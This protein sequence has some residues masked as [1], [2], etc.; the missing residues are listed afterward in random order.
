M[1]TPAG[2]PPLQVGGAATSRGLGTPSA[3]T[4]STT[5]PARRT[6]RRGGS[7]TDVEASSPGAAAPA[8]EG[9]SPSLSTPAT[10]AEARLSASS[11]AGITSTPAPEP[12]PEDATAPLFD[13]DGVYVPM[14]ARKA[15]AAAASGE[16]PDASS[17]TSLTNRRPKRFGPLTHALHSLTHLST[18]RGK[19]GGAGGSRKET[20]SG[21]DS[22][23]RSALST[24]S[25]HRL[26]GQL[27]S[28]TSSASDAFGLDSGASG[29]LEG[30]DSPGFGAHLAGSSHW[31][32]PQSSEVLVFTCLCNLLMR[33]P[34]RWAATRNMTKL[35]AWYSLYSSVLARV[36]P[37][38][39]A[40]LS[41]LGLDPSFY[42]MSWVITLFSNPLGLEVAIRLWDRVLLGGS[43]EVLKC[44][45]GLTK[46]LGPALLAG[47]PTA[48]EASFHT[49]SKVPAPLRDEF[50]IAAAASAIKLT[51]AE[52]AALNAMEADLIE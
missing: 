29:D 16:A 52:V 51:A 10:K 6:R 26:T 30:G 25:S 49:L 23:S 3:R 27:S 43:E 8:V 44:A 45:V 41:G 28:A 20:R 17:A 36:A 5:Q 39:A 48:F 11:S 32:P 14:S 38:V 50:A 37:R 47:G 18:W 35:S 4:P 1:A 33:P 9:S 15:A 22:G 31:L 2:K 21:E 46:H 13:E 40:H 12:K 7:D 34:L 24:S 19:G 42:L